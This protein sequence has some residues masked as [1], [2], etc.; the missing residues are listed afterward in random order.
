MLDTMYFLWEMSEQR[1][2]EDRI[3][4]TAAGQLYRIVADAY[5]LGRQET[6]ASHNGL[7]EAEVYRERMLRFRY[8]ASNE[9]RLG[10]LPLHLGYTSSGR[11]LF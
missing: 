10:L 2:D 8:G 1:L 5:R 7:Y 9:L 11:Q 3:R 6:G 4:S